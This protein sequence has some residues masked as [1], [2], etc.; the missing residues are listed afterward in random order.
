MDTENL[1]GN[2]FSPAALAAVMCFTRF[3]KNF[4]RGGEG[5]ARAR[6]V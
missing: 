3:S 5:A 2:G 1:C 6:E 4:C